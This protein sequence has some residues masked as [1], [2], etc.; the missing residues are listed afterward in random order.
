MRT[1]SVGEFKAHFSQVLKD[2]ENGEKIGITFGRKKEVKAFL[3]PSET[4][5]P[6]KLG[7]LEGQNGYFMKDDF[8]ITTDDEFEI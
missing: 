6:R 2:V 1:M 4:K 7:V 8:Q 5:E 3:V